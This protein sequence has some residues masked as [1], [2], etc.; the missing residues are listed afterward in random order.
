MI[1]VLIAFTRVYAPYIMFPVAL[2][3]GTIGYNIEWS[4]RDKTNPAGGQRE[5][6]E[7]EREERLL[8]QLMVEQDVTHVG[9]LKEKKFVSK[10][11]FEH[12]L[13]P[14]LQNAQD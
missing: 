11:I 2:V 3:V 1:P 5:S 10:S 14:S 9:S 12:N 7:L 6:V 13:S 8:Q 4:L